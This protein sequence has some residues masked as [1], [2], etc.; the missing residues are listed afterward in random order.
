VRFIIL[1]DG[2]RIGRAPVEWCNAA[3]APLCVDP[4]EGHREEGYNGTSGKPYT[5]GTA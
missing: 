2:R 3:V 4:L 5:R 1:P